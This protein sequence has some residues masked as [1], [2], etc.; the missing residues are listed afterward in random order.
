[1]CAPT[2]L[3]RSGLL[4]G[5]RRGRGRGALRRAGADAAEPRSG[6]ADCPRSGLWGKSPPARCRPAR[7]RCTSCRKRRRDRALQGSFPFLPVPAERSRGSAL[8]ARPPGKPRTT[9]GTGL[10]SAVA[11]HFNCRALG[12]LTA[13]EGRPIAVRAPALQPESLLASS[14]GRPLAPA[15]ARRGRRAPQTRAQL[16]PR[17]AKPARVNVNF[18]NQALPEACVSSPS[19][20]SLPSSPHARP[21][22]LSF[23]P[24]REPAEWEGR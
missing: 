4:W 12:P 19:A 2:S 13:A 8:L 23:A 20:P 11:P 1:M 15:S 10:A 17:L 22:S 6:R 5:L 3:P 21:S 24:E 16:C 14:G 9:E 18:A 7:P